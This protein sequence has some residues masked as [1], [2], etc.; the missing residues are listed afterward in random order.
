MYQDSVKCNA[1]FLYMNSP[2]TC[3]PTLGASVCLGLYCAPEAV[4]VPIALPWLT[5]RWSSC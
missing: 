1:L 2:G 5:A 4:Y 3:R